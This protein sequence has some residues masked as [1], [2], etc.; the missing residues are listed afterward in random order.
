MIFL[1]DFTSIVYFVS[2]EPRTILTVM[3]GLEVPYTMCRFID[4]IH[5]INNVTR[6]I[7][8]LKIHLQDNDSLVELLGRYPVDKPSPITQSGVAVARL[9][10]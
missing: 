7:L 1:N 5:G 10:C 9:G 3:L 4:V 8:K 2:V 6:L